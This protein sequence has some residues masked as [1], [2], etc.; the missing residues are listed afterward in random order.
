MCNPNVSE[1]VCFQKKYFRVVFSC[2]SFRVVLLIN[3]DVDNKI[4]DLLVYM[5]SCSCKLININI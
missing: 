3:V 5:Y 2:D 1:V 4:I